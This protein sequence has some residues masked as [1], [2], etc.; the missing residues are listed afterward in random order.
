M[1]FNLSAKYLQ[2]ARPCFQNV[3]ILKNLNSLT[4]IKEWAFQWKMDFNPYPKKQPIVVRISCKIVGNNP[5]PLLLN[6]SRVKIS[7][8]HKHLCLILD[9]KLKFNE[10]L[11]DKIIKCNRIIVSRKM[12]SLILPRTCLLTIKSL[13]SLI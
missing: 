3:M 13:L 2:M 9:I 6:Q 1:V 4:N 7:E 12:L 5:S 11:E 10:Q 8:I